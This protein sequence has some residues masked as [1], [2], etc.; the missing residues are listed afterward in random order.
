MKPKISLIALGVEDVARAAAFYAALGFPVHGGDGDDFVVFDTEGT[1]LALFPYQK[2]ADD[3]GKEVGRGKFP[4][5]TL[6]HNV[7]SKEKV[8]ATLT[9]A[10]N[11]GAKIT[12]HAQDTFWGGYSGYF[13]DLDGHIWEIA[14]NPFADLT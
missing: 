7:S 14:W 6:A 4:G 5:I 11:A 1:K 3:A 12:R 8:D 10:I 9:E 13:E 2:L